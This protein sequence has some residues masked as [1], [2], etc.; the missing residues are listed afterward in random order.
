MNIAANNRSSESSE[1]REKVVSSAVE[2]R[3][4][5]IYN[6][7][8]NFMQNIALLIEKKKSRTGIHMQSKYRFTSFI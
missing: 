1:G 5:I 7:R 6:Y 4:S 2:K 3:E 8:L